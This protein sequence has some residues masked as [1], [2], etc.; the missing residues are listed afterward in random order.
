MLVIGSGFGGQV[1]AI[2]LLRR[3]ITDVRILERR[4]FMGGTWC[5]NSYPGAA[6]DVP[7]AAL[8]DR[9]R[10]LPLDPDVRRAG[11]A[12]RLHRARHRP[13]PPPRAHRARRRGRGARSGTARPGTCG[14]PTATSTAAASWSTPPARSAPPSCRRSPGLDD[15]AG[16][17][18]H[19]NGWDHDVDLAG[20][21]VAVVGSGASAAQV[22]PA[23]QPEVGELH[24]FQRS[25]HWV[26]PRPDRVF[27]PAPAAGAAAAARAAGAAHRDLLE[28]RDPG[29]RLQA[30]PLAAASGSP[31]ARRCATSRPRCPTRSCAPS[32]PPTTR[33]AASGSSCPTRSTPRWAPPTPRSTT[34]PTASTTSTPPAS[35]PRAGSTSTSTSSSSRPATTPPTALIPYDVRGRDGVRLADVWHEFPRA[36]LGTTVPGFPNF[37]VVTGPNTGIGHTSAIFVIESQMEYLMRAIDAVRRRRS[38]AASRCAPTPRRRTPTWVHREMEKTVWHDGGLHLLVPVA[39]GP[40]DRDVPRLLLLLPP[41]RAALPPRP[42]RHH[43]PPRHSERITA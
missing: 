18:F 2:N 27:T 22:I 35:S 31:S 24:V 32:S 19:T 4:D 30:Q 25:P 5:Q 13:P 38:R 10:A 36:Y 14:P 1:T 39:L 28:A 33:S 23:I 20:K 42:P 16:H 43:R 9:L 15:F 3:G 11:R 40:G 6:V 26:L 8:L 34:A 21:R 12:A 29:H 17:A 7:V 41:P 37:F